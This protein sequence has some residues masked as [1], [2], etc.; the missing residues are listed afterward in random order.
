MDPENLLSVINR[1]LE[2]QRLVLENRKLIE[3]LERHNRI[4]NTLLSVS[5]AVAQSLDLQKIIDS[6]LEK[7]AQCTGLEA[8][9]VY[10]CD[11]D[12]LKLTG[13]H[14][15]YHENHRRYT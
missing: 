1:G 3:E 11:K 8:S 5:Q 14:G 6:A 7:V 9:F 2:K 4:T 10:L 13:H 12:K 15:L